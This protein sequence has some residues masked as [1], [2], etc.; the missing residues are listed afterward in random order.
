MRLLHKAGLLIATSTLL[1][2]TACSDQSVQGNSEQKHP[3]TP[4]TSYTEVTDVR[5]DTDLNTISTEQLQQLRETISRLVATPTASTV[6]SCQVVAYGSKPCG[7]P[8]EW[9]IYSREVTDEEQLLPLVDEYNRLTD[10]YNQQEGLMSD[11]AVL[12]P[13]QLRVE[14][15]VCVADKDGQESTP[16]RQ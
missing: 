9:L 5:S 6:E 2:I 4:D 14:N 15:G 10:F 16:V 7:G 3:E 11:C 13:I 12:A 8:S 1:T